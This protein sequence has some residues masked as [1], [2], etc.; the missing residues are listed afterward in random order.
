[1]L[2]PL[3]SALAGTVAAGLLV[4][5]PA[6]AA[7]ADPVGPDRATTPQKR[8]PDAVFKRRIELFDC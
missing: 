2:A 3:A 4:L 7:T 1:M 8:E 6:P 5:A